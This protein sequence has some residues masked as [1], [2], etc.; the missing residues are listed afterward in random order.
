M[1]DDINFRTGN[2]CQEKHIGCSSPGYCF[3]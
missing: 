3:I 2:S 1:V